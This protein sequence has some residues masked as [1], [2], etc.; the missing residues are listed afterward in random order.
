MSGDHVYLRN[1]ATGIR[2][3]FVWIKRKTTPHF[4]GACHVPFTGIYAGDGGVK[5]LTQVPLLST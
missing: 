1:A 5:A 2:I 3:S 4:G